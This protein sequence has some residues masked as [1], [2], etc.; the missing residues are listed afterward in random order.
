MIVKARTITQ[1]HL[2]RCEGTI[3]VHPLTGRCMSCFDIVDPE[4]YL[5]HVNRT[6]GRTFNTVEEFLA[7][8]E[9]K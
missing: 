4:T 2:C 1:R 3:D 7:Y 8:V 6:S 5:A 9:V